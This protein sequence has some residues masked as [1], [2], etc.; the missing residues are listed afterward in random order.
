MLSGQEDLIAKTTSHSNSSSTKAYNT[1]APA[2]WMRGDDPLVATLLAQPTSGV[3]S[4]PANINLDGGW[5]VYADVSY[6]YWY[7]K[8][9][10]FSIAALGYDFQTSSWFPAASGNVFSQN[11][12]YSSGFKVS[13]GGNLNVDEWAVDLSYSY[14]RNSSLTQTGIATGPTGTVPAFNITSWYPVTWYG[15]QT[16]ASE[17]TSEWKTHVD[18]LDL[19]FSRSCYQGQRLIMTPSAGIR[20][21]WIRQQ[22][23]LTAEDVFNRYIGDDI[24][25]QFKGANYSNSWAIGPRGWLGSS[26]L[27]GAG[28]RL[29][30]GLGASLSI[31]A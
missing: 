21:S 7:A 2:C 23:H 18:W 15:G 28:I 20:A 31:S 4:C 22:L 11:G 6:L 10:G 1:Q 3:Y 24:P 29:Q 13:I 25:V 16:V 17:I 26:W 14:L 27:L 5:D 19:Q 8:Q 12:E 9:E 30:G